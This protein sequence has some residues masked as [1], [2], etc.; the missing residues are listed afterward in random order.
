MRRKVRKNFVARLDNELREENYKLET[1]DSSEKFEAFPKKKFYSLDRR[2]RGWMKTPIK[3]EDF[4]KKKRRFEK[5]CKKKVK[6]IKP[7]KNRHA[8]TN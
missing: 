3:I 6:I 1:V 7:C 4:V 8:V 2:Y 5:K